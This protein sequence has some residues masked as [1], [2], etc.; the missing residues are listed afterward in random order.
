V[1]AKPDIG[2]NE[3]EAAVWKEI[4]R[5]Q[6]DPP[7]QREV[8]RAINSLEANFVFGV[9]RVGGFGGKAD[10]LN[11]YYFRTGYPD[12]FKADLERYLK[13][14]PEDV[15]R[16]AKKYLGRN[17]AVILSV[18]PEGKLELQASK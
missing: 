15:Q 16:V 5:V 13:V 12:G 7:S 1:T 18:V 17:N 11:G 6:N 3:I 2:L 4:E 14:T 10:N 8:Q 9:Q